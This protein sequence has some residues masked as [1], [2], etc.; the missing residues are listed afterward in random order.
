[1][2]A[3]HL[4]RRHFRQW[5]FPIRHWQHFLISA[6]CSPGGDVCNLP[7][8]VARFLGNN[9]S[10]GTCTLHCQLEVCFSFQDNAPL[11]YQTLAGRSSHAA[12]FEKL[13]VAKLL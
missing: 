2:S 8:F 5:H 11:L 4:P 3:G 9:S 10:T 7:R 1:L 6:R 13:I 12:L